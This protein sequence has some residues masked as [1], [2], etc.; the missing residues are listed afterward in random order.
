MFK[1]G[2]SYE[3][4]M[5]QRKILVSIMLSLI[6]VGAAFAVFG[7]IGNPAIPSSDHSGTL[8]VNPVSHSPSI[9]DIIQTKTASNSTAPWTLGTTTMQ[10]PGYTNGTFKMGINCNVNTLNYFPANTYCDVYVI[11]EIYDG[12]FSTLP[13]GTTIPWLATGYTFQH[14]NTSQV[15]DIVTNQTENYSYIYTIHLRPY[16]QW[17]DWSPQNASD[18]YV[19]PN[20]TTYWVAGQNVT[21]TYKCFQPTVMKTYYLQSA[22]VVLSWRMEAGFGIWPNVVN[23]IPDGNLTV[24]VYVTSQSL[25]LVPDAFTNDILPF[26]IWVH[27]DYN[28]AGLWNCTP[29]IPSTSPLYDNGYYEWNL[30]WNPVT[31][32]A[33]GLVGTGPFMV[34]NNYGLPQ[35]QIITSHVETMYVNPHYFVQYANASSGLRQYT[36]KF[37]EIYEPFYT[38]ESGLVAGFEKGQIDTTSLAPPPSFIPEI[39]T[40]PGAIVYH[41]LSSAYGYFRINT[42]IAPLNITAFRQAL[43]YAT[44][45]SYMASVIADGYG[46]LSS[47]PINPGNTLWYNASAPEYTFNLAKAKQLIAS[48]PGMTNVSG[49]LYYNGK[50]VV[51]T[52]ETTVGAVAPNNIEDIEAAFQ[53]WA[54]LGIKG[55]LKEEAFTTLTSQIDATISSNTNEYEVAVL[56]ISTASGD[57]AL[58]CQESLNPVYGIPTNSYVG[59]F[60][61]LTV[62]GHLLNGT[63]VQSLFDNLTTEIVLTDSFSTAQKLVKYLQTL[64]IEEA[65]MINIGYGTDLVPLQT[66]TFTNYSLTETNAVYIYWYWQFF[67]IYAHTVSVTKKLYTLTVDS[68]LDDGSTFTPGTYGNVTFT[69]LNGTTPVPGADI[70]VGISAPYGGIINIT[71]NSLIANSAG[72]ATWEY[73]I[74]TYLGQSLVSCNPHT[75]KTFTVNNETIIISAAA[76]QPNAPATGPGIG[77]ASIL[78]VNASALHVTYSLSNTY[79]TAGQTGNITFYVTEVNNGTS[80][81]YSGATLTLNLAAITE[82]T[83]V[84]SKTITTNSKGYATFTFKVNGNVTTANESIE[85]TATS[86]SHTIFGDNV[87]AVVPIHASTVTVTPPP[88]VTPTKKPSYTLDY[89]IIGVVVVVVAAGV[90]AAVITRRGKKPPQA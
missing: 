67:S 15:F 18:T 55:V 8:L 45:T 28:C 35:G 12:M 58:D 26:H 17:T 1:Y 32:Y 60:S 25:L 27:H 36:P 41:K 76:V 9:S 85:V 20:S 61:S 75:K 29:S 6:M 66:Y 72:Q 21:Y 44:P 71:S 68:Q 90:G 83:N 46:I 77:S 81:P 13:N 51:I 10:E 40:T 78:A 80:T 5:I 56:G 87:T 22:D 89:I 79:Y 49:T 54:L 7:G 69:V 74:P 4:A 33:P 64:Y 48:I 38:S 73:Y 2:G 16:V 37:Y 84:T 52:I 24:K 50:P 63:Q 34:T 82:F 43:N 42:R 3:G 65:T 14:V 31:G 70:T 62:N 30:S 86:S 11:D 47:D 19:F 57:P 59:P 39:S 23:V 88:P 53:D